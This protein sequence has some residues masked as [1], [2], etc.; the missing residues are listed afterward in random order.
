MDGMVFKPVVSEGTFA[1]RLTFTMAKQYTI[2]VTA[3]DAAGNKV[4][5]SRNV[6][7]K[8]ESSVDDD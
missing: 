3:T 5:A 8:A 1:Q 7:Y 4:S 6:I 2:V